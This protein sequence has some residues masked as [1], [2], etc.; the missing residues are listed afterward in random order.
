MSHYIPALIVLLTILAGL[1]AKI[2]VYENFLK[3]AKAGIIALWQIAPT[4]FGIF[5]ALSLVRSSLFWGYM[6]DKIALLLKPVGISE[7]LVPLILIRPFSGSASLA[8]LTKLMSQFGPDSLL[9]LTAST[10]MAGTETVFYV[11]M[12]YLASVQIKRSRHIFSVVVLT[13]LIALFG[14]TFLWLLLT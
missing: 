10:F 2:N 12:T 7:E 3:G 11:V 9:G 4:V 5:M 14:S 6:V 8:V 13:Q 1:K